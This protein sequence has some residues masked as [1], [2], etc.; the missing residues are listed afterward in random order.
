MR[1]TVNIDDRLLEW[2]KEVAKER[3]VSLGDVVDEALQQ[4]LS[5]PLH[6]D[7]P[8]LP[9]FTPESPGLLPGIDPNSNR[10]LFEAADDAT[11]LPRLR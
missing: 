5:H 4:L 9:V 8:T 6:G 10:S 2:A 1:T 7:G 11:D 3:A